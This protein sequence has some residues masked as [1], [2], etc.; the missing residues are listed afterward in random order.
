MLTVL[1][2]KWFF[3]AWSLFSVVGT[4]EKGQMTPII[5]KVVHHLESG[6]DFSLSGWQHLLLHTHKMPALNIL[7][8]LVCFPVSTSALG[9]G[10]F[11]T[12]EAHKRSVDQCWTWRKGVGESWQGEQCLSS[13]VII[14]VPKCH[15]LEHSLEQETR[16]LRNVSCWGMGFLQQ[17]FCSRMEFL[18]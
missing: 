6:R 16:A 5:S 12:P 7:F 1:K 15:W 13:R 10:L 14:Y 4:A 3:F 8:C 9:T 2:N 11:F 18:K 17:V